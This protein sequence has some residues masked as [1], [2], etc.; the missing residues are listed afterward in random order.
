M[1][2]YTFLVAGIALFLAS[3]STT[4][5][6]AAYRGGHYPQAADLYQQG[7]EQGDALAALKLGLLISEEKVPSGDYGSAGSWFQKGCMLGS[8]AS[9]HNAGVSLEYGHNGLLKDLEQARAF[10]E[11]AA[12]GGYMQSQYNLG[13]L[14]ANQYFANDVKGYTWLLV[15]Q[16]QAQRCLPKPLCQWILDDPPGHGGNLRARM[17]AQQLQ[18]ASQKASEWLATN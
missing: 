8:L 13:S 5:G 10:Y 1:S 7:A 9:C 6:D 4:P 14:Y 12:K 3:C 18:I 16:S 11:K 15:S 17:T 2:R